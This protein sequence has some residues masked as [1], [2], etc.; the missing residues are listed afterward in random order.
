[1][2]PS[3]SYGVAVYAAPIVIFYYATRLRPHYPVF[4]CLLLSQSYSINVERTNVVRAQPS[5][6][7]YPASCVCVNPAAVFAKT[8]WI[9]PSDIWLS[10]SF[11][12]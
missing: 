5:T 4:P 6:L 11:D 3:I 8:L 12:P 2:L 9:L 10:T 1:M 7:P